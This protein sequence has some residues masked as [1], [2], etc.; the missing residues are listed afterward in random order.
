MTAMAAGTSDWWSLSV[1][2]LLPP[3]VISFAREAAGSTAVLTWEN[4]AADYDAIERA[5]RRGVDRRTRRHDHVLRGRQGGHGNPRLRHRRAR[6]GTLFLGAADALHGVLEHRLRARRRQRRRRVRRS[7]CHLRT[8]L[9]VRLR[10]EAAVHRERQR[11]RCERRR[12]KRS[13][14]A[15]QLP[16]RWDGRDAAGPFPDCGTDPAPRG[17]P[18][19]WR[20]RLA[21]ALIEGQ[22]Q[23]S[24]SETERESR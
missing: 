12:H 7:R 23:L 2:S 9:P 22:A 20:T 6:Y 10:R 17:A 14:P 15:A 18:A 1:L 3:P 11:E 24:R 13:H 4:G 19:A 16:V 21:S 5:A 8:G